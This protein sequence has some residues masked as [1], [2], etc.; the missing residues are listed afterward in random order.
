MTPYRL[1]MLAL[2]GFLGSCG[3]MGTHYWLEGEELRAF[4]EAGP[5]LPE[6]DTK[7]ILSGMQNPGPYKVVPGDL[8]EIKGPRTLSREIGTEPN[9]PK[10]GLYARVDADGNVFLP[11]LQEVQVQGLTLGEIET[12]IAKGLYPTFLKQRPSIVVE[13]V[14]YRRM[15]VQIVGAV[16]K[17]GIV[18]LRS[19]EMTLYG[20]LSEAG[21]ILKAVNLVVGARLIRIKRPGE[22]KSKNTILPVKGLNIP[23]GDVAL[24]GGETIEVERYEPDTFTAI[25]LV[26]KPGAYEYP[27]EVSYNLMQAL[28]VAGGVDMIADPPYATVFRKDKNGKILAATFG[29]AGSG[30][31]QSSSFEIKPG[32]VIAVEHTALSWTRALLADV[33]RINIGFF[34][35]PSQN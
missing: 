28:A 3:G 14:D 26:K 24:V 7:A 8:L 35:D 12:R 27:P 32:D 29:I 22:A 9:D 33:L 10:Q 16:E 2:L 31:A 17:P 18:E 5:I 11:L 19:D 1:L 15:R 20:A 21:G 30:M 6:V 4:E 23:A 25:G 34:F 13:V